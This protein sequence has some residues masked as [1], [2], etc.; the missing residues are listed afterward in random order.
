[1]AME[2]DWTGKHKPK[3]ITEMAGQGKAASEVMEWLQN[4][5]KGKALMLCGQPGVGKTLLAE[6]AAK[7]VG[8]AVAELNASDER[9]P[10][11]M[12]GFIQAAKSRQLFGGGKVM[13]IDEADGISGR[14]DRGAA[15]AIA[16]L[17]KDSS[18]PVII[19]ANDPYDQKLRA[20]RSHCNV[21]RLGKVPSPSITKY[22]RGVCEKEGIEAEEDALKSLARWANGDMRSALGDLQMI[23]KGRDKLTEKELEPLGFRE[24]ES[25][26][27]E[28]MPALMH[29]GSANAARNAIRSG[30]KDPDE[31]FLWIEN[32][33]AQEFADPA[34]LAEA[35]DIIS[36]ADVFRRKVSTQ[37]NWRFKA[38]M[39]D[40]MA[41][42]SAV[43]SP[44]A[45]H[46]WIQY[47]PPQRMLMLGR[48]K[49]ERALLD[50][51]CGKMGEKMKCSKRIVKRDYLPFLKIITKKHR[52]S[53]AELADYFGLDEDEAKVL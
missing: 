38:Y 32:N 31:I 5:K 28:I 34:E 35:F 40:L 25:S 16:E 3:S 24:R 12:A 46:R 13:V 48:S 30:D 10:A 14:S 8:L 20:I 36:R 4:W 49:A 6:L 7:E 39:V 37:Q 9:T 19:I 11:M 41:C 1:M 2:P 33:L 23:A 21:I 53:R 18:Y 15:G 45:R 51:A 43:G 27:F 22:L 29:S 26:I 50:G 47:A 42:I 52:K 17:I 44:E